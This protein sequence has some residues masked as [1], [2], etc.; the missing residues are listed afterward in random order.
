[1]KGPGVGQAPTSAKMARWVR[2]VVSMAMLKSVVAGWTV[3]KINWK[4]ALAAGTMATPLVVTPVHSA[5]N[6]CVPAS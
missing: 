6:P 5:S 4:H 3:G 2:P 1:M